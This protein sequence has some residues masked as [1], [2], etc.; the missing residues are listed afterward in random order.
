MTPANDAKRYDTVGLPLGA[1]IAICGRREEVLAETTKAL[2]E[3]T[4]G[5]IQSYGCD[6]R[7]AEAVDAMSAATSATTAPSGAGAGSAIA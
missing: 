6:I 2:A 1:E 3:K 7:D 4:G 5:K